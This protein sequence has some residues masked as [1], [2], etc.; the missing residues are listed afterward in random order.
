MH[1][2]NVRVW[3]WGLGLGFRIALPLKLD[4]PRIPKPYKIVGYDR[5]I[6]GLKR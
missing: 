3:V 2:T 6:I 4:L 5:R 1:P